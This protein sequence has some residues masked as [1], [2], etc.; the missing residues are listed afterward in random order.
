MLDE[1]AAVI[2]KIPGG[3]VAY[4]LAMRRETYE[5]IVENLREI[6]IYP[7][8]PGPSMYLGLVLVVDSSIPRHTVQPL[9]FAEYREHLA[10]GAHVE[11]A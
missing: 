8:E 1:L 3:P 10:R 9:T 11:G 2:E 7:A 4:A 5:S 6:A